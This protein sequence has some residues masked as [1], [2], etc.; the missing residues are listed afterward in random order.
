MDMLSVAKEMGFTE[1]QLAKARQLWLHAPELETIRSAMQSLLTGA[2]FKGFTVSN[3]GN[4]AVFKWSIPTEKRVIKG[5]SSYVTRSD[6]NGISLA[7]LTFQETV[8]VFQKAFSYFMYEKEFVPVEAA[9]L[10]LNISDVIPGKTYVAYPKPCTAHWLESRWVTESYAYGW[11][12]GVWKKAIEFMKVK[13]GL[14]QY[15]SS[16][17]SL[18]PFM[19]GLME[20]GLEDD[21]QKVVDSFNKSSTS[22][23][24]STKHVVGFHM[25]K[26]KSHMHKLLQLGVCEE[27]LK[28]LLNEAV[29]QSV[30]ES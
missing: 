13:I 9:P 21:V 23:E 20:L 7:R 6:R 30:L 25:H 15:A 18:L 22:E 1:V 24:K 26:I 29:V 28:K 12:G 3:T 16:M 4:S 8:D 17:Y 11:S 14:G 10:P 27:D 19:A 5:R 2:S